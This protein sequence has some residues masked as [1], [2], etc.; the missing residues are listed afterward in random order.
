MNEPRIPEIE[1]IEND[2]FF[3]TFG[4]NTRLELKNSFFKANKLTIGLQKFDNNHKQTAYVCQYMDIDKALTLADD[5]LTGRLNVLANKAAQSSAPVQVYKSQGGQAKSKRADGKPLYR[6]FGIAKGKLWMF[7][8]SEGP[9]KINPSTRGI[10]SDGKPE[11]VVTVGASPDTLRAFALMIKTEYQAYRT[12]QWTKV[13]PQS[14][15]DEPSLEDLEKEF[16]F[17]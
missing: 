4:N 3:T 5:I 8:G 9:G 1:N 11:T 10:V 15:D 6:E 2:V 13:Q 17:D 7:S 16:N 12:A 14:K